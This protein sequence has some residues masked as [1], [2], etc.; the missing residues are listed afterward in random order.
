MK[1]NQFAVPKS[2]PKNNN[3]QLFLPLGS[4]TMET[5]SG[6]LGGVVVD[7]LVLEEKEPEVKA[8]PVLMLKCANGAHIV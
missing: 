6:G 3:E 2:Q 5:I 7:A 8:S 1:K 4:V